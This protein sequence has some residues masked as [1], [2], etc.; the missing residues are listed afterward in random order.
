[1]KSQY[2]NPG[3]GQESV[4]EYPVHL[5]SR[6]SA[7]QIIQSLKY[8]RDVHEKRVKNSAGN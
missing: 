1:M 8:K 2:I 6:F 5:V 3:P 7:E 4:W